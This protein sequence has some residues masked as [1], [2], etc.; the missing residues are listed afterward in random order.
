MPNR[1]FG[2]CGHKNA[3]TSGTL[4]G[5]WVDDTWAAQAEQPSSSAENMVSESM[6]NYGPVD[7]PSGTT[8]VKKTAESGLSHD[9]LISHTGHDEKAK[10][11][12][13]Y[14]L[15]TGQARREG[16]LAR[17]RRK[18]QDKEFHQNTYSTE[19]SRSS[20]SPFKPQAMARN[21]R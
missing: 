9:L 18:R 4:C 7:T 15:A 2:I 1:G 11:V 14:T 17:Q 13:S 6:R 10:Y 20:T 3:Y 8:E 12:T 5:N 21:T 19:M 16:E